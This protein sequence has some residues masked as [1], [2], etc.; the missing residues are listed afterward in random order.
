MKKLFVTLT[1]LI[2][3][4]LS[5]IASANEI[6]AGDITIQNP[7]ARATLGQMKNGAT[8][9][10]LHNMGTEDDVLIAAEGTVAKRIELHAHTMTDGVM[11]MRQ[12]EGGVPVKASSMVELKPG[13]FHIMMMGLVAPL[14]KGEAFPLTLTF[15]KAGKVDIMVHIEKGGAMKS[16]NDKTKEHTTH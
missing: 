15:E 16:M 8:F 5:S 13:G 14:K 11:K 6:K 12:V 3:L 9:V 2:C 1:T 7:W 4:S 10:T